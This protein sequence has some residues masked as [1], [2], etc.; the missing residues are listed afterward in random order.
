MVVLDNYEKE[1]LIKLNEAARNKKVGFIYGGC[2]GLYGLS[3]VDFGNNHV[4]RDESGE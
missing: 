1:Y 2:L 3:F 4:V